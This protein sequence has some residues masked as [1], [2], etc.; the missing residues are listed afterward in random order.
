MRFNATALALA[1]SFASFALPVSSQRPRFYTDDPIGAEPETQD[2]SGAQEYEIDLAADLLINSVAKLG[3]GRI[4]LRAPNIN[5]IDEV[6]DSSWFTNRVGTRPISREELL[7]G[8]NTSA[9][10]APARWTVIRPKQSGTAPGFTVQ[11][12]RGDTWFVSFD[13]K[14]HPRAATGA[15]AVATRIFWALGYFQTEAYLVNLKPD[16]LAVSE[17]AF[18]RTPGHRR[19]MTM[20]DVER[21][22][23]RAEPNGDGSYRVLAARSVPGRVLGG[24][25]YHGTRPDDPNDVVPHEHR[26]ELRALKVFAAWTNL[27]DIKAGNTLDT[28][29]EHDGRQIIRHYLQDVGSTFGTGALGPREWDEGWEH[30]F[31][32]DPAWKR[33]VTFGFYLRPWQTVPYEESPEIGRFEGDVFD[34]E[35]WRSRVPAPPLTY[36]RDDDTFWAA[37]RVAAFT[38]EM[39]RTIASTGEY[40]DPE[41]AMLLGDVLIK[42]R[43]AI[44]RAYLPRVNPLVGFS[45]DDGG[46]SFENAAT[47]H[48]VAK[49]PAGGYRGAWFRFDNATGETTPLGRATESRMERLPAPP[50]L[51]GAGEF[52]KVE[53]SADDPTRPAWKL[54]VQVYFRRLPAGW[55]LVGLDRLP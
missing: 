21:V 53:V 31:E 24:F 52:V 8:P 11:D 2:A 6:P 29:V 42:R 34:P 26:R 47:K 7:T 1:I 55:K 37:R 48:G 18:I 15:I 51:S 20:N 23:Q 35:Q 33:L 41:A 44:A 40:A 49:P 46:L 28:V 45:L 39:I 27:V 22:L 36:A 54:P 38:D 4:G 43:D 32:G 10:P 30:L 17:S 16:D 5:T 12:S 14:G 13:A 50:E 9:G 25:R 19:R 3:D